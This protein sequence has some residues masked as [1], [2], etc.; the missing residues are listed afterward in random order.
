MVESQKLNKSRI[1][2]RLTTWTLAW[3]Y[4]PNYKIFSITL[5]PT[6]FG[7]KGAFGEVHFNMSIQVKGKPVFTLK[8]L[9]SKKYFKVVTKN[10]CVLTAVR[11]TRRS[12]RAPVTVHNVRVWARSQGWVKGEDLRRSPRGPG[13]QGRADEAPSPDIWSSARPWCASNSIK[14]AGMKTAQLNHLTV[15]KPNVTVRHREVT[16]KYQI[17]AKPQ[18]GVVR[19]WR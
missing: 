13:V 6:S 8:V 1:D 18:H 7:L 14:C 19:R 10:S 16:G 12:G 15:Y 3:Q 5:A 2:L 11:V 4:W 9:L 17:P